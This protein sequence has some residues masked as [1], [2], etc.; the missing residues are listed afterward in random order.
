MSPGVFLGR[1]DDYATVPPALIESEIA[2]MNAVYAGDESKALLAGGECAQRIYDL[3]TV[4]DLVGRITREA[5]E[6]L[7]KLP[8]RLA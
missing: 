1:P 2:A 8:G 4:Q 5:E 7:A 6:V 3:P